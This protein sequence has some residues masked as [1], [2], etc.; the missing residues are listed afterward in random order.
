MIA[1]KLSLLR[2]EYMSS[3]V[4]VLTNSLEVL[5]ITKIDFDDDIWVGTS[6]GINFFLK[7]SFK[8]VIYPGNV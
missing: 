5:H 6:D 8:A 4:N 2:K 7:C 1:L 3:A